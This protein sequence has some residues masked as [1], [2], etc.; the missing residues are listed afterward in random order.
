MTVVFI[1]PL[2]TAFQRVFS[3]PPNRGGP[4]EISQRPCTAWPSEHQS[5]PGWQ[6]IHP[7]VMHII[8]IHNHFMEEQANG[9]IFFFFDPHS[10]C[11]A[12]GC[13]KSSQSGSQGHGK[14]R[15][16]CHHR[17]PC[18]QM[19]SHKIASSK[20]GFCIVILLNTCKCYRA[21][22]PHF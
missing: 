20:R 18:H 9:L 13:Y 11:L 3:V 16:S 10:Y 14:F 1:W 12:T 21:H 22:L 8:A 15:T 6:D 2:R 17:P 19:S 7:A 4:T 5:R